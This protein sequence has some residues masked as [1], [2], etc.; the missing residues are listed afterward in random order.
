MSESTPYHAI[1][2]GSF[3]KGDPSFC[4]RCSPHIQ[5][6]RDRHEGLHVTCMWSCLAL[7]LLR[8]LALGCF[9]FPRTVLPCLALPCLTVPCP[10]SVYQ[11]QPQPPVTTATVNHICNRQSQRQP[12]ITTATASRNRNRKF[13]PQLPTTTA[14]ANHN[15][16]HQT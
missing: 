10:C 7:L 8:C 9:T 3:L 11:S 16:N 12:R 14:T 13:Q 5:R 6:T 15:R 2:D 1:C 4:V